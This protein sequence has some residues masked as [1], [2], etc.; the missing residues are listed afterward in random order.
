LKSEPAGN[1]AQGRPRHQNVAHTLPYHPKVCDLPTTQN[2]KSYGQF[3]EN[4]K[5]SKFGQKVMI[6]ENA[7]FGL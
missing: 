3:S 5:S 1:V 2:K 4:S 7:F 6:F